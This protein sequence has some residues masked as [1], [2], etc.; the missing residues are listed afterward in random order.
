MEVD[1]ETGQVDVLRFVSVL[2]VGAVVNPSIVAGQVHGGVVQGLGEV[3]LESAGYGGDG[4]PL[5]TTFVDYL[6][7]TA[8]DVPPIEVFH[9][10]GPPDGAG[11]PVAEID[12]RGVGECGAVGTP[13]ALVD[14]IEDALSPFGI[15]ITEQHLS[16]ERVRALITGAFNRSTP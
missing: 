1:V 11:P 13:A 12:F 5:A 4:Q 14:A 7:P 3:L 16:P 15:T 9:L 8:P 2:D 6:L 10:T